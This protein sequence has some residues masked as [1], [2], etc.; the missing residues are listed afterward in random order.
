MN[1]SVQSGIE[2]KHIP[3]AVDL[4][5]Q[6]FRGKLHPI[7]KPD[8]KALYFFNSII[9]PTYAICVVSDDG[10]LL[11]IAGFKTNEGAFMGGKLNDICKVYGWFGGVWRGLLLSIFEKQL[12]PK[13][14]LMDGI[15]V[16]KKARGQGVGTRLL[17]A[18]KEKAESL[19]CET[20]RLDVID[21]NPRAQ[22][23]YEREGFVATS[24][25]D[26]SFLKHIFGFQKST[27]MSYQIK[28]KKLGD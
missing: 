13:T 10:D 21:K 20:V 19:D 1:F 6:A 7:M 15:F 9:N 23:L 4:F 3:L 24:T 28:N 14:F 2:E 17:T 5:W 11:G 26:I 22:A 18:I 27:Q 12:K 8:E 16:S 25:E